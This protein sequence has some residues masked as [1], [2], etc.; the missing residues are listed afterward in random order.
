MIGVYNY[1]FIYGSI[2]TQRLKPFLNISMKTNVL[3]NFF[4]INQ[5]MQSTQVNN[6][7]TNRIEINVPMNVITGRNTS[8]ITLL[9]HCYAALKLRLSVALC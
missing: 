2:E 1:V 3:L 4:I 8:F 7:K 6:Y 5:V 9:E